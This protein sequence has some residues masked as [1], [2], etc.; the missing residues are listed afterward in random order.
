MSL[1]GKKNDN[2]DGKILN[3]IE[4]YLINSNIANLPSSIIEYGFQDE[5]EAKLHET[6]VNE[7]YLIDNNLDA[8]AYIAVGG[9]VAGYNSFSGTAYLGADTAGNISL[10]TGMADG[11][12]TTIELLLQM[13]Q[14]V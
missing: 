1:F 6:K 5:F 13:Y 12:S 8:M 9:R 14:L 3:Y 4:N 11:A 2:R 10:Y 7:Q